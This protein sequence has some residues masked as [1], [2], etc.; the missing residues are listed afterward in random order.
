MRQL[1]PY[2][3][4]NNTIIS[5]NLCPIPQAGK[6]VFTTIKVSNNV[7]LFLTSHLKR[8]SLE[9]NSNEIK[10]KIDQLLEANKATTAAVRISIS[11]RN[12]FMHATELPESNTILSAITLESAKPLPKKKI[13]DRNMYEEAKKE[14]QKKQVDDVLFVKKGF[15]LETTIANIIWQNKDG[16][17]VTPALTK[18]GLLGTTVGHLLDKGYITKGNIPVTTI[19]PL[20]CINSLRVMGIRKVNNNALKNPSGLV[21]KI[22]LILEREEKEYENSYHR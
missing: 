12:M 17:L 7:P 1:F 14:A 20:A 3:I 22:A 13:I 18:Q 2:T 8:L 9:K 5:T 19:G 11:S 6:G 16:D 15:L 4:H 21:K 10:Q